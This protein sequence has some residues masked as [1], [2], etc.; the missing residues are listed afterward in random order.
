[1]VDPLARD[2]H[3]DTGWVWGDLLRGDS[4]DR[5]LGR[6]ILELA[7]ERIAWPVDRFQ[8]EPGRV[9]DLD[10]PRVGKPAGRLGELLQRLQEPLAGS[11]I[12]G[13]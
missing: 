2:D 3:R 8:F 7:E 11:V 6:D 10:G 13:L 4:S 12:V 5:V 1:L 9:R